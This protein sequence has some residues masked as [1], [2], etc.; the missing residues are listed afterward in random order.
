MTIADFDKMTFGNGDTAIYKGQKY[1]VASV[2]FGEKL[3]GLLGQ[4]ESVD[5]GLTW[6]RCENIQEY[7]SK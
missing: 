3:I 6:V 4:H 7:I 2:D 5:D 1:Q